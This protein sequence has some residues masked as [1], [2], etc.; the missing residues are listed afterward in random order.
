MFTT[1]HPGGVR[2]DETRVN[3]NDTWAASSYYFLL[4]PNHGK[5]FWLVSIYTGWSK[6]L[7]APDDYN[8]ESYK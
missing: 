8:T 7:C 2:F 4:F 1:F 6:C 3:I 5:T